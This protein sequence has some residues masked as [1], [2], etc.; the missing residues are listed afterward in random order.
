MYK[1]VEY[2]RNENK[3]SQPSV[4]D[5]NKD[6]KMVGYYRE[7]FTRQTISA[8]LDYKGCDCSLKQASEGQQF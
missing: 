5:K 4:E 3:F 7:R 1:G 2:P 6:R 8:D